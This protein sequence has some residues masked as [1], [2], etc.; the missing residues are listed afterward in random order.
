M[1]SRKDLPWFAVEKSTITA[2]ACVCVC[3]GA[4]FSL[5]SLQAA[6]NPEW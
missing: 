5:A 2:A 4:K 3:V 6:D 1:D